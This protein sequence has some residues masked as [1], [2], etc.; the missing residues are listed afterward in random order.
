MRRYYLAS[1][2]NRGIVD[3][4][5][6]E[7]EITGAVHQIMPHAQVVVEKGCYIVHPTPAK[8]DAIRIGRLL[9][10]GDVMGEYCIKISK[11]FCSEEIEK[12]MVNGNGTTKK[13]SGG[14]Q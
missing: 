13:C 11:L 12:G 3:L 5:L 9:S 4:R 2:A 1:V 8:G 6:Y 14:H 10:S 7:C